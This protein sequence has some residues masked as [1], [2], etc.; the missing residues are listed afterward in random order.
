[1]MPRDGFLLALHKLH[2]HAQLACRLLDLGLEEQVID[3]AE[4]ARGRICFH[5]N[6]R[7]TDVHVAVVA[8][9]A[10]AGESESSKAGH[11]LRCRSR[12]DSC[13]PSGPQT[14]RPLLS[15]LAPAVVMA[16][17]MLLPGCGGG[18]AALLLEELLLLPVPA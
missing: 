7:R 17:A 16:G 18:V 11:P 2:L 10:I 4:D 3:E 1:M 5:R 15:F 13:G 14:P 6:R 9:V 8:A 12:C